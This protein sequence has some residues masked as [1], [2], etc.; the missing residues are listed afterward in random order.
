MRSG[1]QVWLLSRKAPDAR[2]GKGEALNAAIR[3]LTS[4][5]RLAGRDP[6][7][8]IVVVVDADGR[9]DPHA[10]TAVSPYFADPMVGAVQIG[11]RI[12]NRGSSRLARMQD[13]EFVI[14]T[15]VFQRGRRHLGSVGLGGNGQFMRLSALL[16]LG[17]IAVD[18]QPDR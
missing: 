8:V 17:R 9:L 15:E 4:S 3:F 10:V 12:N 13:M 11:V 1:D 18:P 16:S 6:D 7:Q 5:G 2:Q 14:Y